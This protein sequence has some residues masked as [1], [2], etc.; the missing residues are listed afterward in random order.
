MLIA[1]VCTAH[2]PEGDARPSDTFELGF[3]QAESLF[4][5]LVDSNDVETEPDDDF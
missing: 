5:A 3:L 1:G 4:V 2:P